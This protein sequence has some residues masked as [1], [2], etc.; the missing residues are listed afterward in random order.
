MIGSDIFMRGE[1]KEGDPM[2]MIGQTTSNFLGLSTTVNT[3]LNYCWAEN[4]NTLIFDFTPT[5][6]PVIVRYQLSGSGSVNFFR[7]SDDAPLA[8]A[9][10]SLVFDPNKIRTPYPF[11]LTSIKN[12]PS[13]VLFSSWYSISY[14]TLQ[15][16]VPSSIASPSGAGANGYFVA[17]PT[18]N[19]VW[20]GNGA[21][22]PLT[23]SFIDIN[24]EEG[25]NVNPLYKQWVISPDTYFPVDVASTISGAFINSYTPSTPAVL[26]MVWFNYCESFQSCGMGGS[27]FGTVEVGG[28]VCERNT[29]LYYPPN[30]IINGKVFIPSGPRG[31]TGPVGIQGSQGIQGLT[32]SSGP[33][34]ERGPVA[35]CNV[36]SISW[37]S[38]GGMTV[39]TLV[40]L[41]F[42]IVI[43]SLISESK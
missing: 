19:F 16:Q 12:L 43:F 24:A 1:V 36:D 9:D 34:G 23:N 28:V 41:S 35:E 3:L 30:G 27:C 21:I 14:P 20:N 10:R 8:L 11:T 7:V 26:P 37:T 13:N 39:M 38:P 32:G 25:I 33:P 5:S 17:A 42:L 4:G 2:I 15:L 29:Q 40:I 18:K 22:A 31:F 6:T